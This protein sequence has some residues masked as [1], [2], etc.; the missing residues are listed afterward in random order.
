MGL[1]EACASGVGVAVAS[2]VCVGAGV[3]WGVGVGVCVGIVIGAE[4]GVGE[5]VGFGVGVGDNVGSGL[6]VGFSD[7]VE[8][9]VSEGSLEELGIG[10]GAGVCVSKA[11]GSDPIAADSSTITAKQRTTITET[12]VIAKS[13]FCRNLVNPVPASINGFQVAPSNI[14]LFRIRTLLCLCRAQI[15]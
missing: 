12:K 7:A 14:Y 13:L 6:A 10:V 1:G 11:A 8:F 2:G 15:H 5:G 4:V 3:N 9:G